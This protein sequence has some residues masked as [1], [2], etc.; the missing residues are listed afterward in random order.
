MFQTTQSLFQSDFTFLYLLGADDSPYESHHEPTGRGARGRSFCTGDR[1]CP[2][3]GSRLASGVGRPKA[4]RFC[5]ITRTCWDHVFRIKTDSKI[6]SLNKNQ[7]PLLEKHLFSRPNRSPK[8]HHRLSLSASRFPSWNTVTSGAENHGK[9][10]EAAEGM[11][12]QWEWSIIFPG[13]IVNL[14]WLAGGCF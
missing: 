9:T 5:H 7:I 2:V 4:P 14:R 3:S 6:N 8:C 1:W 13:E 11:V 12:H 10:R